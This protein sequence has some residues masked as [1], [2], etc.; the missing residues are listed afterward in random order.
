[1]SR[2]A[3]HAQNFSCCRAMRV[4]CS[5]VLAMRVRALSLAELGSRG[6]PAC[7]ALA[8]VEHRI[9]SHRIASHRIAS[10]SIA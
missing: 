8:Q 1:V 7:R 2:A 5:A 4:W 10:H 6:S 3:H 9:A